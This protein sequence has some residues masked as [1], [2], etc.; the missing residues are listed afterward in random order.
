MYFSILL[1]LWKPYFEIFI[2]NRKLTIITFEYKKYILFFSDIFLYSVCIIYDSSTLNT[3][4]A[5]EMC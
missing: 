3:Y 1:L 5:A 4:M 2:Y